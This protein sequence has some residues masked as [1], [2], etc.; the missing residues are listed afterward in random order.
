[1]WRFIFVTIAIL[2]MYLSSEIASK[3]VDRFRVNLV[4]GVLLQGLVGASWGFLFTL[5]WGFPFSILT[6]VVMGASAMVNMQ[7]F[8]YTHKN[9]KKG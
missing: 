5:I 1:M 4:V 8:W 2:G 7:A 3:V 9:Q 6:L